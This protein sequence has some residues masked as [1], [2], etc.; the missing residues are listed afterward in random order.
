MSKLKNFGKLEY[1]NWNRTV[2]FDIKFLHI[3]YIVLNTFDETIE[4]VNVVTWHKDDDYYRNYFLNCLSP[5]LAET[6][7]KFKIPKEI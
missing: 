3:F 6:Y 7:C 4:D 5:R 1:N 2:R